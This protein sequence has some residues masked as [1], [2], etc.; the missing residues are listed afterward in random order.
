ML[1]WRRVRALALGVCDVVV[2]VMCRPHFPGLARD[3]TAPAGWV[4]RAGTDRALAVLAGAT[5]WLIAAWLAL[6]IFVVAAGIVP[7]ALGGGARRFARL[8][9]PRTVLQLLAA[10]LGVSVFLVPAAAIGAPTPGPSTPAPASSVSLPAPVWPQ[11]PVDSVGSANDSSAPPVPAWPVSG[12]RPAIPVPATRPAATR[13]PA[14][15]PIV[16]HP[17]PPADRPRV[18]DHAG[19]RSGSVR[20]HP[21]DSLWLIAARRLGPDATDADIA[22][23]WPRWYAANHGVIGADPD[24]IIPG[25]VL[26]APDEAT[27]TTK[28]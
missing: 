11:D 4:E 12:N 18:T 21:G 28:E 14:S 17:R 19:G 15:R 25:Q 23:T 27:S 26:T 3:L 1:L 24:L 8:V 20:V 9:L 7:G 5:L 16:E 10:S 13:P 22:A 6:G 2:L